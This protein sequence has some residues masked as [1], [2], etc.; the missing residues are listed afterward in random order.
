[1]KNQIE[2]QLAWKIIEFLE[3]LTDLIYEHYHDE[4]IYDY[5]MEKLK[6]EQDRT[7]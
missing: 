7:E 3:T 6:T 4:F 2:V 1:M 5:Y